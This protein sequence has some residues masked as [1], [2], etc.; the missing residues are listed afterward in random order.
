[1]DFF[2]A[3]GSGFSGNPIPVFALSPDKSG[4]TGS[5]GAIKEAS[6]VFVNN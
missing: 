6:G 4:A 2:E 3:K 5:T 1:L